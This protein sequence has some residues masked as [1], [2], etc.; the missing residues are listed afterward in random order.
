M[1]TLWARRRLILTLTLCALVVLL[2]VVIISSL[3]R[4]ALSVTTTD[5][6]N[7]ATPAPT[8]TWRPTYSI[9]FEGPFTTTARRGG[10]LTYRWSPQLNAIPRSPARGAI[11][12]TFALYGPFPTQ[13]DAEHASQTDL[14]TATPAAAAA[15]VMLDRWTNEPHP[16]ALTVPENL[17]PGYYVSLGR[18]VE[19]D[20]PAI[21]ATSTN[22]TVVHVVS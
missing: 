21:G 20:G 8:A 3:W 18:T 22:T 12:C 7:T 9:V 4:P 17:A 10:Q 2:A 11:T 5:H 13:A 6:A 14:S 1:G 15:P 16:G 19:S